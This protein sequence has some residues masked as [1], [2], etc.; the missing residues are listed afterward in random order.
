MK[1]VAAGEVEA[2]WRVGEWRVE[3]S[4][5]A[6]LAWQV[7]VNPCLAVITWIF[8]RQAERT[9]PLGTSYKAGIINERLVYGESCSAS[10]SGSPRLLT[11][12]FGVKLIK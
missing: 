6:G 4:E 7:V 8:P 5:V 12:R 9:V 3:G 11:V 2:A 1:N 10:P